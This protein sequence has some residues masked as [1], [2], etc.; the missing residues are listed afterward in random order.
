MQ[1]ISITSLLRILLLLLV[2]GWCFLIIRPFLVIL[3]WAI[4]IAVAIYPVFKWM[5]IKIGVKRKKLVTFIFGI[6]AVALLI[7]PT[8]L[9]VVSL[10]KTTRTTAEK[11]R[12]NTLQVPQPREDVKSWPLI[13]EDLYTEWLE[14]SNN[15]ETYII[16]HKD[17]VLEAGGNLL[18]GVTGFLGALGAFILALLISL[19]LMYN[20]RYGYDAAV[21]LYRKLLG[22]DGKEIVTMCR[23]TI[24]SVVKGILV[25]A[26]IQA[27]LAFLGFQ[28]IG[29]PA[30]G[31]WALAVFVFAVVQIPGLLVF[32]PAIVVAFSIAEPTYATIF[33]VYVLLVSFSENFL[34]PMLLG[35]GLKTPMVVI[36]IGALGGLLLH[37]IVGLFVGPVVLAVVYQLYTYWVSSPEE[38]S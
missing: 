4:I 7:V 18:S 31:L 3:V 35:Q 21:E 5:T 36:L 22:T 15:L 12:T 34:K 25:V 26:L 32:I 2:L 14:I 11:L 29:L 23:D 38:A 17:L 10:I 33:A 24:R 20:A 6:V 16:E 13:G 27:V 1:K 28:L 9:V 30:S 37:G 8:Y 19:I